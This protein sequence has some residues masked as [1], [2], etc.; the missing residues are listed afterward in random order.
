M[1][2]EDIIQDKKQNDKVYSD[3][4]VPQTVFN[5]NSV[6]EL[7]NEKLDKDYRLIEAYVGK[8]AGKLLDGS[9]S[10]WTFLWGVIYVLYRKM[11][12]LGLKWIGLLLIVEILFGEMMLIKIIIK[13]V[14]KFILSIIFATKFKGRYLECVINNVDKIKENNNN[15]LE[16]ELLKICHK[17]GG[18]SYFVV[19]CAILF[20][21]LKIGIITYN[22]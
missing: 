17:K 7:F 5:A 20:W 12:L 4:F 21:I 16:E 19:V 18:V 15:K 9:F 22:N 1:Y 14:I 8:N 2:E 6:D 3:H 11:W 10:W 13:G